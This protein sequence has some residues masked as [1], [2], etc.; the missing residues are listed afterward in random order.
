MLL[1]LLVLLLLLLLEGDDS[2]EEDELVDWENIE[3]DLTKVFFPV[4]LVREVRGESSPIGE[5]VVVEDDD[6]D[7]GD[8]RGIERGV[9]VLLI[10]VVVGELGWEIDVGSEWSSTAKL[11]IGSG[12]DVGRVRRE[13]DRTSLRDSFVGEEEEDDE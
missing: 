8:G 9:E 1:L 7:N 5:G 12:E 6:G 11:E 2:D 10:V 3:I 13:E 4:A